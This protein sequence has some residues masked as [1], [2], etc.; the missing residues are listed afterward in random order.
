MPIQTLEQ[1][2]S[3][4]L[5]GVKK[6][7]LA[8][9]L[10]TFPAEIL[11]LA[12]TLQVLDL[13]GNRLT[14][15]PDDFGRL[16]HLKI[17]FFS[18][19]D[20]TEFPVV[21]ADCPQLEMIG[22]KANRICHI[23]EAALTPQLR[24]LILT[25]NRLTALPPSIGRCGRLQKLMLA[26]N[27]LTKLPAEMAA[28]QSLELL[29]ISANRLPA[30][31]PWLLALPRLSWLAFGGNPGSGPRPRQHE[32]IFIPWHTLRLA[33]Q[34]GEGAS[35][36]IAKAEWQHREQGQGPQP[37][38]VKVFKGAV[39]SDGLPADEMNACLAA[40]AH[41]NLV[42]V[43]GQISHH[44]EQRQ[45][46]VLALI[47]PAFRNLGGPPSMQTCTRDTYPAG[48]V[49]SFADVLC[50]AAG[51]A[52]AAAHLHARGYM[53]GDLYAHNILVDE[54][55]NPILGDFGAAS[56]Y[57][58]A[59][60]EAAALERLEARAFGCL[61]EDLLD[62]LEPR[63]RQQPGVAALADLKQ[64]CMRETVLSRPGFAA[65]TDYL[66]LI[67]THPAPGTSSVPG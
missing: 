25:D 52:A 64:A 62:H 24:W 41:P 61:L 45:G 8:A 43:L 37:V 9:G 22:F 29:R 7:K 60:W 56:P 12:D 39:T 42:P 4:A 10:T 66:A 1:L 34:L 27:L 21:M 48:T 19:N 18:D 58:P 63:D 40:G 44:P 6:L 16:Q 50:I 55:A 23:P 15:L 67:L 38:A 26:G 2:R 13:S 11:D 17:A 57:D 3:G 5:A 28:C 36:V 35:G 46:L 30:L 47:P 53:H 49:F 20:F 32:L 51:I 54:E 59:T 31:P 65:I 33:E 14:H